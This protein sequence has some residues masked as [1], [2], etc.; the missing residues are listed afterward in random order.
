MPTYSA[1]KGLELRETVDMNEFESAAMWKL[2]STE[3][4]SVCLQTTYARLR[5]ALAEDCT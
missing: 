1:D 5:D 4:E 3:M 2:Y